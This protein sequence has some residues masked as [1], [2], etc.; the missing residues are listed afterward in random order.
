MGGNQAV[1]SNLMMRP[2][3]VAGGWWLVNLAIGIGPADK[4]SY[5]GLGHNHP[6]EQESMLLA[7]LTYRVSLLV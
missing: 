3:L 4:Q 6:P 1:K 7:E 2:S 5:K